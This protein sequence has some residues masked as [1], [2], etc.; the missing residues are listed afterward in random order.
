M[1]VGAHERQ[2]DPKGRIALPAAFRP[3]FEPK[4]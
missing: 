1:F 3:K 2:L 4:C